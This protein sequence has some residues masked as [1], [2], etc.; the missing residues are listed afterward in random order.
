V[1]PGSDGAGTVLAIGKAVTRFQPSDKVITMLNQKHISG[2]LTPEIMKVGTGASV[3]GTF[4]EIGAFNEEA[5][6]RL[7]E[8]LT[9]VE[10]AT[11]SCAGVT[12]WNALFGLEGRK[13]VQDSWVLTQG[14]G[15]S[16]ERHVPNTMLAD[17]HAGGVS[18]FALQF[19]K[20]VGAKVIATTSSAE[21]TKLLQDLG[22]NHV[23]NYCDTADWGAAAKELT[24]GRGVDLVVDVAGATTLQD[25]VNSL[26]IDGTISTLGFVGGQGGPEAKAIPNLLDAWLSMYTVRGIGVGNRALMEEMCEAISAS[27]NFKPVIDPRVFKLE[28]LKEAYEYAAS[29]K[30]VGKIC[31]DCESQNPE[32]WMMA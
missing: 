21:K 25:S 20:L 22:A 14:T 9:S 8:G 27:G 10:A 2:F 26:K 28:Q 18:L 1:V 16:S 23:I 31:I 4:R 29:G 24:G 17:M 6:V 7:P 15:R 13:V 30:H 3:D 19:A 12:A 11:L 5:L 32:R